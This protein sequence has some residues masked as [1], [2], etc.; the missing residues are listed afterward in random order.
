MWKTTLLCQALTF[1]L[2]CALQCLDEEGRDV[3]WAVMYKLP[4]ASTPRHSKVK[5]DYFSGLEYAYFTSGAP[6]SGWKLSPRLVNDSMSI[7]GRILAPL[8]QVQEA[9][10]TALPVTIFVTKDF[11]PNGITDTKS[12]EGFSQKRHF[13]YAISTAD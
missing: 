8:Y 4:K 6:G 7:P 5:N 13:F 1:G 11:S 2:S 9:H 12:F 3:D 10:W